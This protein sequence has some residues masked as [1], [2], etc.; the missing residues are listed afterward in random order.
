MFPNECNPAFVASLYGNDTGYNVPCGEGKKLLTAVAPASE[1]IS[2]FDGLRRLM[3]TSVENVAE[4]SGNHHR[5]ECCMNG[6]EAGNEPTDF[7]RFRD[8]FG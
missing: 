8:R 5:T 6:S 4:G 7:G 2:H 1:S 3:P